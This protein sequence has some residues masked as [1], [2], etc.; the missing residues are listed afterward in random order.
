MIK[1]I[2]AGA[3]CGHPRDGPRAVGALQDARRPLARRADPGTDARPAATRALSWARCACRGGAIPAYRAPSRRAHGRAIPPWLPPPSWAHEMGERS[4]RGSPRRL[5][6]MSTS[7][8]LSSGAVLG[9]RARAP[10]CRP[11]DRPVFR[12]VCPGRSA[13]GCRPMCRRWAR[14]RRTRPLCRR[15]ASMAKAMMHMG[16]RRPRPD[17]PFREGITQ[18]YPETHSEEPE[19]RAWQTY[20]AIRLSPLQQTL[21]PRRGS[22]LRLL[23]NCRGAFRNADVTRGIKS[24]SGSGCV[25]VH[26]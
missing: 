10:S 23:R 13:D 16:P 7:R 2:I 1:I 5:G 8:H 4:P 22:V 17:A 18:G 20:S 25:G 14:P 9:T 6:H 3:K 21:D 19:P 15:W 12:R 26:T 24:R 11:T